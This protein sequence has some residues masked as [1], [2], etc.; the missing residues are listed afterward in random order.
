MGRLLLEKEEEEEECTAVPAEQL[1]KMRTLYQLTSAMVFS[2]FSYKVHFQVMQQSCIGIYCTISGLDL[3]CRF[4]QW[5]FH[6][7]E[8]Y[9]RVM[10]ALEPQQPFTVGLMFTGVDFWCKN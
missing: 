4:S 10:S 1:A 7:T 6:P 3:N 2:A 9:T 8:R 5:E